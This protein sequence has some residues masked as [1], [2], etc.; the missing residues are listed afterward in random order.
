MLRN[1]IGCR[2]FNPNEL[3]SD[4]SP[5]MEK[6]PPAVSGRTDTMDPELRHKIE[7]RVY[8]LWEADG[9]PEGRALHYWSQAEQEILDQAEAREEGSSQEETRRRR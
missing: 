5:T 6:L 9:R 1:V 7:E 8:S 2:A 4:G 3:R